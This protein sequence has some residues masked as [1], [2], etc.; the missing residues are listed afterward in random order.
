MAKE[1]MKTHDLNF[2]S[3]PTLCGQQKLSY[4][5]LDL[6]FSPYNSYWKKIRK[7]CVVHLFNPIECY[8]IT[9]FEKLQSCSND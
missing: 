1:I 8:F 2:F 3:M 5:G 4:N 7:I 6:G 9:P